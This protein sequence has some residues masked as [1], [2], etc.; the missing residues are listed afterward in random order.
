[1]SSRLNMMEIDYEA[2]MKCDENAHWCN[3]VHL[4]EFCNVSGAPTRY[5][6]GTKSWC[7]L[8]GSRNEI[9]MGSIAMVYNLAIGVPVLEFI[10]RSY[11]KDHKSIKIYVNVDA[12]VPLATY[13]WL[14]K[15]PSRRLF[16]VDIV[17][18]LSLGFAIYKPLLGNPT[19][20]TVGTLE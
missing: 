10:V 19:P 12:D 5:T 3:P 20:T 9:S 17:L 16:L 11:V 13:L 15:T 4:K 6:K 7:L 14:Q 2:L 1:M 18:A 8:D